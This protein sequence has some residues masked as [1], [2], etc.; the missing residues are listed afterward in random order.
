MRFYNEGQFDLAAQSWEP[1]A[2]RGDCDAEYWMGVLYLSGKSKTRDA[3]KAVS[4]WQKAANAGQPRAQLSLADLYYQNH[5]VVYSFCA[6]CGLD[7]DLFTAFQWYKLAGR[8][9]RD[10]KEKEYVS[11]AIQQLSAEMSEEDV[12]RGE[13]MVL[14][15][16][17]APSACTPRRE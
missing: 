15:W 9:T 16:S 13:A 7:K 14:N 4:L 17:P 1:L 8:S 3:K 5:A 6:D 12:R 11:R 2:E 10:A